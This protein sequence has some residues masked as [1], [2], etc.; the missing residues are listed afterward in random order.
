MRKISPPTGFDPR[1]V[2]PVASRYTDYATW[3]P[4][5]TDTYGTMEDN[6]I[7]ISNTTGYKKLRFIKC[8]CV[9]ISPSSASS[10][11]NSVGGIV[12]IDQLGNACVVHS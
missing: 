12:F 9:L 1:T 3:L 8:L 2:Q 4:I 7:I 10:I 6:I 5:V 11:L